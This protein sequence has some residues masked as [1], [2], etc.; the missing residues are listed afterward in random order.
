MDWLRR[1]ERNFL[2]KKN[3]SDNLISVALRD[4]I[5]KA[6]EVF[7][8]RK[9]KDGKRFFDNTCMLQWIDQYD[10]RLKPGEQIEYPE[11]IGQDTFHDSHK[12]M[13]YHKGRE[14][15]RVMAVKGKTI[16]NVYEHFAPYSHITRYHWPVK[17]KSE[18]NKVR[19]KIITW[20]MNGVANDYFRR[21]SMSI[22]KLS[23]L[24]K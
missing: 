9:T 20:R 5:I 6:V 16:D 23:L 11:F 22:L 21:I 8:E 12:A 2:R 10:M 24:P 18:T 17:L 14:A 7:G 4:Y 15:V 13:L 3:G 1:Y 19:T